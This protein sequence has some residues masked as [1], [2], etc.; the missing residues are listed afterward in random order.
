MRNKFLL[1][2]CHP[3]C[4]LLLLPKQIKTDCDSGSQCLIL[5]TID[6]SKQRKEVEVDSEGRFVLTGVIS[7]V[8]VL[9][10]K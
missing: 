3:V 5:S 10:G 4:G 6:I 1:F 8:S 7:E 2:I 9:G